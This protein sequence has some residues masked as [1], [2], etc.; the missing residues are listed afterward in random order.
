[1]SQ[2]HFLLLLLVYIYSFKKL[3]IKTLSFSPDDDIRSKLV[4]FF[5]FSTTAQTK[6]KEITSAKSQPQVFFHLT[7]FFFKSFTET[8]SIHYFHN[9]KEWHI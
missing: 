3:S 9:K 4:L 5:F 8:H 1:M 6:N 2:M 7:S